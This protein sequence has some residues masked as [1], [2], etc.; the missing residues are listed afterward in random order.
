MAEVVCCQVI[1]NVDHYSSP[2]RFDGPCWHGG[3]SLERRLA[4]AA[5]AVVGS[6]SSANPAVAF[7]RSVM[8]KSITASPRPKY[9]AGLASLICFRYVSWSWR[10]CGAA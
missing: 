7:A 9:V 4:F 8:I 2:V 5:G 6:G 10:D 1:G 3:V